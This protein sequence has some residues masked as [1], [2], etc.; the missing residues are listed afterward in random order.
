MAED[1]KRIHETEVPGVERQRWRGPVAA[2]VDPWQVRPTPRDVLGVHLAGADLPGCR[3]DESSHPS[4][5]AAK[6]QQRGPVRHNGGVLAVEGEERGEI[7]KTCEEEERRFDFR[8]DAPQLYRRDRCDA[9][10][11]AG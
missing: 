4:T 3:I 7:M 6:I 1:R 2:R 10:G 8:G 9:L 5:P 11:Q